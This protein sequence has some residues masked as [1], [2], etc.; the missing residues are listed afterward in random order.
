MS[1]PRDPKP[2][3]LQ[4]PGLLRVLEY[5]REN[6]KSQPANSLL[7]LVLEKTEEEL[8][9]KFSENLKMSPQDYVRRVRIRLASRDLLYAEMSLNQIATKHGFTSYEEF[10]EEFE[11]EMGESP[12]VYRMKL[13][14]HGAIHATDGNL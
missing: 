14:T 7:A 9:R 12:R 5:I 3:G 4:E 2:A 13:Y 6:Y 11:K 8:E 10:I 1:R